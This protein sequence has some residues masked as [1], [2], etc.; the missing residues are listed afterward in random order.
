MKTMSTRPRFVDKPRKTASPINEIEIDFHA[1]GL[2]LVALQ[3]VGAT[4]LCSVMSV[5]SCWLLPASMI[6]A[7]RTLVICV[8]TGVACVLQPLRAGRVDVRTIFQALRPCVPCYILALVVEQLTHTCTQTVLTGGT[9]KKAV[10]QMCTLSMLVAG[11][12]RSN[13]P[14]YEKDFPVVILAI[15]MLVVAIFPPPASALSGPLCQ[16]VTFFAGVE[17]ALRALMFSS[18]YAVHVY[19]S[20]Q[21]HS[22]VYDIVLCVVRSGAAAAWTL[23]AHSALLSAAPFQ[24]F[25]VL[26]RRFSNTPNEQVYVSVDTAIPRDD[27]ET[28]TVKY[29]DVDSPPEPSFKTPPSLDGSD[30]DPLPVPATLLTNLAN[31]K[32]IIGTGYEKPAATPFKGLSFA[33]QDP[34]PST[35]TISKERL[36]RIAVTL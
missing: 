4:V 24:I 8:A 20:I 28:Y 22:G 11:F 27:V 33:I 7:V 29:A 19:A 14:R 3:C 6:S 21:S 15:S 2:Y 32:P 26:F 36:E 30:E 23:S 5:L 10:F 25:L 17:R 16:P 18:V 1:A 31:A 34:I 13:A 12:L 35:S 9:W